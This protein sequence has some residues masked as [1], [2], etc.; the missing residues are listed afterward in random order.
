MKVIRLNEGPTVKPP[1]SA[2]DPKKQSI[3]DMRVDYDEAKTIEEK[4]DIVAKAF[5][6]FTYGTPVGTNL[7][8]I[9]GDSFMI[10]FVEAFNWSEFNYDN[11]FIKLMNSKA[12]KELFDPA[13]IST[14][15]QKVRIS[16]TDRYSGGQT[17]SAREMFELLYNSYVHNEL[18]N[19]SSFYNIKIEDLIIQI[20]SKGTQAN[21]NKQNQQFVNQ[22]NNV[23][24]NVKSGANVISQL[25]SQQQQNMAAALKQLNI[26]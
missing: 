23:F 11:T 26:N 18:D 17:L 15:N 20:L 16:D 4:A 1:V 14:P 2:Y 22:M 21:I 13:T 3:S 7:R 19:I 25:N 9:F 24:K 10:K 5:D 8:K 6:N 12:F